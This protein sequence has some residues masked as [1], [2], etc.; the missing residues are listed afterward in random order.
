[1]EDAISRLPLLLALCAPAC[2][3]FAAAPGDYPT[4]PIRLLVPYPADL[5]AA[6]PVSSAVGNVR[7]DGP[8]L[9]LP[10]A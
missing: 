7:N 1:M 3:C 10:V 5:M 9:I 6:Y 4:R 2:A 8:E